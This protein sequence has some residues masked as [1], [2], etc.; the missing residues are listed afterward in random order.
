MRRPE[1]SEKADHQSGHTAILTLDRDRERSVKERL[2]SK[3]LAVSCSE[4]VTRLD[5]NVQ[6]RV[7]KDTTSLTIEDVFALDIH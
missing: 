3:S 6:R 4:A 2:A 7:E 1:Y 5:T